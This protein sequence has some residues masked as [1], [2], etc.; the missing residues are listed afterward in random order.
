MS[1]VTWKLLLSAGEGNQSSETV[2]F[3]AQDGEMRLFRGYRPPGGS[4]QRIPV[5]KN[6]ELV[7]RNIGLNEVSLRGPG[8]EC[9]WPF[10]FSFGA[11]N[12]FP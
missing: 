1:W 4:I 8:A 3:E 11:F 2:V 5:E 7:Y 6:L 12:F 9:C 10:S